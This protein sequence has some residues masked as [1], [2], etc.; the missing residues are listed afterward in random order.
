MV[1]MERLGVTHAFAFDTDF[2]EFGTIIR[3]P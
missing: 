1:V 3:V 2:E